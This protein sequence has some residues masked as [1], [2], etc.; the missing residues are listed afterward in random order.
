MVLWVQSQRDTISFN[1]KIKPNG[2]TED[3]NNVDI[4]NKNTLFVRTLETGRN[5]N[6]WR[7]F[8]VRFCSGVQINIIFTDN[9]CI[10]CLP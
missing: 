7:T 2:L 8:L 5:A 3:V 10:L 9:V 6:V 4:V 1:I